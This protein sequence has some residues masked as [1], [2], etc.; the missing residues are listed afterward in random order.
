MNSIPLR[1][2]SLLV[3]DAQQGFTTFCPKELP[4]PGGL[5]I[6]SHVNRLLDGDGTA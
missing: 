4:V 1:E 3:V 5:E 2:S 6:V